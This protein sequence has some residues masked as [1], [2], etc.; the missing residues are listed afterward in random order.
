MLECRPAARAAA[1]DGIELTLPTL[2]R[3][4][5]FAEADLQIGAIHGTGFLTSRRP[6]PD[7]NNPS[8]TGRNEN[9][10][11]VVPRVFTAQVI[12][13]RAFQVISRPSRQALSVSK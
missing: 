11:V 7:I 1:S 2:S 12:F 10:L 6:G 13:H 4:S 5:L 9:G 3:R 8:D